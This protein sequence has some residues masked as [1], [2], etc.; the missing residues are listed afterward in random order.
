MESVEDDR[1]VRRGPGWRRVALAAAL[2][3]A[4][5]AF[6]ALGLG[7]YFSWAW[8]REHLELFAAF[9]REHLLLA[10]VVFFLSY[11]AATALSLPVAGVLSLAAGALFGRWLAAGV[12]VL[13][14]TLGAT[15]ACLA[16]RYLLRD[17][18]RRHFGPRLRALDAGVQRDGAWYL[19][20]LRLVPLFPFFLVNLGMGLTAMPVRTFA[21]VSLVGMIPG[22]LVFT[23][24]GAALRDVHSPADVLSPAV[25]ASL[26]L[27][28]V[29]PLA[30]RLVLRRTR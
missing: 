13:A 23:N 5:V 24:A 2:V 16:S 26:A 25:L 22:S 7:R 14:A 28:G 27:L 11:A 12:V 8:V 17:W 6:H 4:V 21:W 20:T 9:V 30:V 29:F 3:G 19:F 10:A 1:Q 15:G 18:V